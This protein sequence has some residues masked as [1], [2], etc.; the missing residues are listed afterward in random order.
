M[1]I[2]LITETGHKVGFAQIPPF[3]PDMMPKV[4]IWGQRT[5]VQEPDIRSNYREVFTV[6]VPEVTSL[7][8]EEESKDPKDEEKR[9]RK[10]AARP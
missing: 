5:F 8:F 2:K 7:D 3:E 9:R 10:M 6:W 4:V 1:L